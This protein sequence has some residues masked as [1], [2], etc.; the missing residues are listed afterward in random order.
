MSCVCFDGRVVPIYSGCCLWGEFP[1]PGMGEQV[2][3]RGGYCGATFIRCY[4]QHGAITVSIT[5]IPINKNKLNQMRRA[6][7][8][9]SGKTTDPKASVRF[10]RR[11]MSE[12]LDR[13]STDSKVFD[14]YPFDTV[15][16]TSLAEQFQSV[17][18]WFRGISRG[19]YSVKI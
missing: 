1:I 16:N 2:R 14:E 12:V 7:P 6:L 3:H 8:A 18:F 15:P 5:Q 13:P 17:D 10:V 9:G 19:V 4:L 11:K